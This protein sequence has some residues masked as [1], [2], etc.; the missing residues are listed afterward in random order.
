M[1]KYL[2]SQLKKIFYSKYVISYVTGILTISGDRINEGSKS[3][4]EVRLIISSG[5]DDW[6]INSGGIN[7]WQISYRGIRQFKLNYETQKAYTN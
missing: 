2:I 6:Q 4:I 3:P 5:M 1:G 7:K